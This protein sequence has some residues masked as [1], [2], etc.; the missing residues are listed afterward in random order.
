MNDNTDRKCE[1]CDRRTFLS[2]AISAA[3][4][5]IAPGVTLFAIPSFAR[6]PGESASNV[7]RWG[8]LI[9]INKCPDGCNECVNAC[10]RENGVKSH[11]RPETDAK[12]IRKIS[13]SGSGRRPDF[14]IPVMCQ[15]C[16]NPPCVD[17]CPT[18]ASMKRADGIV[19]VDKHTC[20]GCRYCMIACPYK[21]RSFIH[22]KTTGQRSFAPRGKGTVESCTFCVH[23]I[24]QNRIPACVE[25][26]QGKAGGAMIFGDLND[27]NSAISKALRKYPSKEIRGD[28]NLKLGVRY[29]G[30]P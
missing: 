16:E 8:L 1:P 30:I 23:R 19:L 14:E 18:G 5:T 10:H 26:C 27:K 2:G 13:V 17:V 15:H 3:S 4:L 29:R 21:A 9:D 7:N 28:L 20:I 6:K 22:E 11:G 12:W 25:R 24:D